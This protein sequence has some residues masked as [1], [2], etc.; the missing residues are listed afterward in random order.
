MIA[1]LGGLIIEENHK[2]V[3]STLIPLVLYVTYRSQ[4]LILS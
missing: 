4:D 1:G 2:N 3:V